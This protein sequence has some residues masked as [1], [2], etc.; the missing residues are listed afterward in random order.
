MALKRWAWIWGPAAAALFVAVLLL[1]AGGET[2]RPF[3]YFLYQGSFGSEGNASFRNDVRRAVDVQRARLRDAERADS[4][5]AAARGPRAVR[6]RDG[7]VAVAYEVPLSA[8]DA[9]GWLAAAEKEL[10]RYPAVAGPGAPLVVALYSNPA[11]AKGREAGFYRWTTVRRL[12]PDSPRSPCVVEVNLVPQELRMP[13]VRQVPPS[14]TGAFLGLC[15]LYQRFGVPGPE[16]ARW[17]VRGGWRAYG[18][19]DGG[20][21]ATLAEAGRPVPRIEMRRPD[22]SKDRPWEWYWGTPWV[23]IGCLDGSW[24]LCERNVGIRSGDYYWWW[25]SDP[26]LA[27]LLAFLLAHG[28]SAQF[29]AFWRS[30]LGAGDALRQAYGRPAGELAHDAFSH[31]YSVALGGPRARPRLMLAGVF[32]AAAALALALVAGRRWTTEI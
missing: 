6:S 4:L 2:G 15:G 20:W 22:L 11:R 29:A 12:P 32:W 7:G 31:W 30:P 24:W 21:M 19:G 8:T 18:F 9:R 10:A 3:L 14:S 16:I 26:R 17:M 5:A 23:A 25:Y 27:Q 1:P 13:R 28:T